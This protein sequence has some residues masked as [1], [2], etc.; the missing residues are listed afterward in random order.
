MTNQFTSIRT[1]HVIF[2]APNRPINAKYPLNANSP[3]SPEE[4]QK[5]NRVLVIGEFTRGDSGHLGVVSKNIN[6]GNIGDR[7]LRAC[8]LGKGGA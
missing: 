1:L 4:V 5:I 6:I 8:C 3:V 2:N 7:T